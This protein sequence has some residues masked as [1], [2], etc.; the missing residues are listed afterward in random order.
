MIILKP[1]ETSNHF[2][3]EKL[4]IGEKYEKLLAQKHI[5]YNHIEFS[6][7][8]EWDIKYTNGNKTEYI[9]VKADLSAKDTGNLYIEYASYGKP[10]GL[11]ISKANY[12]FI[13]EVID[14]KKE[15]YNLYKFTIDEL[16]I[17]IQGCKTIT[18]G[19]LKGYSNGYLLP[20]NKCL[21]NRVFLNSCV[22][23]DE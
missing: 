3:K 9:E 23:D 22:L 20:K 7:K 18:N 2:F 17:L 6:K 1:N 14:D 15:K 10:S 12:W 16:K 5:K 4:S 11:S 19:G 21:K 8:G 13:F